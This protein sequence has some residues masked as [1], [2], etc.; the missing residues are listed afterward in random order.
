MATVLGSCPFPPRWLGCQGGGSQCTA[1]TTA[2]V[3]RAVKL[4]FTRFATVG[5]I[6]CFPHPIQRKLELYLIVI[7]FG[8]KPFQRI[9]F[10]DSYCSQIHRMEEEK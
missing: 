10:Y 9:C 2:H 6:R 7:Y 4:R 8:M 1:L 3:N 5:F